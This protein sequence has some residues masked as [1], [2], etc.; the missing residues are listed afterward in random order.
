MEKTYMKQSQARVSG[1]LGQPS[2]CATDLRAAWDTYQSKLQT[3]PRK[4]PSFGGSCHTFY[5]KVFGPPKLYVE[6]YPSWKHM[7]WC[8]DKNHS[9]SA[10]GPSSQ[11]QQNSVLV[12]V[13]QLY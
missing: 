1:S 3:T 11:S 8:C 9:P 5:S 2:A 13:W 12:F 7:K 4:L 6:V 10:E